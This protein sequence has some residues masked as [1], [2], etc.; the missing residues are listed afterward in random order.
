M[1]EPL[2]VAAA[3]LESGDEYL[4]GIA[5]EYLECILP[6]PVRDG[7]WPYL[8]ADRPKTMRSKDEIVAEITRISPTVRH[9]I[10]KMEERDDSDGND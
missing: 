7:L 1:P 3:S 10:L 2:R 9:R 4:R 6:E 5:L 8:E